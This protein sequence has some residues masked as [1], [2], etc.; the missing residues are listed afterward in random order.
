MHAEKLALGVYLLERRFDLTQLYA[1]GYGAEQH[2]AALRA[3]GAERQ[4]EIEPRLERLD[5]AALAALL[6]ADALDARVVALDAFGDLERTGKA[7]IV[8]Q[9]AV[10]NLR[11]CGEK[12]ALLR[13]IMIQQVNGMR[14]RCVPTLERGDIAALPMDQR[15]DI[16]AVKLALKL[17]NFHA[18]MPDKLS[19]E[20]FLI[21]TDSNKA[22]LFHF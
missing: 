11:L 16:R 20:F 17:G 1:G 18:A 10:V 3:L 8:K 2:R 12:L 4:V 9:D 14:Q 15:F 5:N 6:G 19:Q 7:G 13:G 22:E 21:G